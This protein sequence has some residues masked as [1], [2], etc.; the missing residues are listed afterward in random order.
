[1][2]WLLVC[3]VGVMVGC[4]STPGIR[5]K[6]AM[7]VKAWNE[8]DDKTIK[9]ILRSIN[10][11]EYQ[12]RNFSDSYTELFIASNRLDL[13]QTLIEAG[14]PVNRRI[15]KDTD[16]KTALAFAVDYGNVEIVKYLLS[17][18]ADVNTVNRDCQVPLNNAVLFADLEQANT[19]AKIGINNEYVLSDFV[20]HGDYKKV[21]HTKL[22]SK[23]ADYV[24]I[25]AQL[26]SHGAKYNYTLLRDSWRDGNCDAS[27]DIYSKYQHHLNEA[28]TAGNTVLFYVDDKKD[29][30]GAREVLITMGA[31][32]KIRNKDGL[33]AT[34]YRALLDVKAK[35]QV[36][37]AELEKIRIAQQ[38]EEERKR[39]EAA[40]L[41]ELK[42]KGYASF[43]EYDKALH[44]EARARE[45]AKGSGF[46]ERYSATL[47][48]TRRD[49]E[50][51]DNARRNADYRR[52]NNC[53]GGDTRAQCR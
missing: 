15:K 21:I 39:A 5:E 6:D 23:N 18:G 8:N 28:D 9:E 11:S 48:K 20:G 27:Y 32:P 3:C 7:F 2:K 50:A 46:W 40:Y 19:F 47:D 38:K 25:V 16:D 49:M 4:S 12:V 10:E 14:V 35:E 13:V 17:K 44:A 29:S 41:A 1:M 31:N 24:E 52:N 34:E 42:A 37:L 36:R 33:L 53:S 30:W 26:K 45:E 22:V 43:E 51:K